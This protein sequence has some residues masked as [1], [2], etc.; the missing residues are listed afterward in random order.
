MKTLPTE[1][2]PSTKILQDLIS[3]RQKLMV[4]ESSN[5]PFVSKLDPL[6]ERDKQLSECLVQYLIYELDLN[7][8]E[9][10]KE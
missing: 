3:V 5:E 4:I 8:K 10:V 2:R 6:L 9:E 7:L 1:N